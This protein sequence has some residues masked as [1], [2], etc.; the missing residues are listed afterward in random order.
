MR[1]R[2]SAALRAL[3]SAPS[4]H[5][6]SAAVWEIV[7]MTRAPQTTSPDVATGNRIEQ[8]RIAVPGCHRTKEPSASLEVTRRNLFCAA[9]HKRGGRDCDTSERVLIFFVVSCVA[10]PAFSD[11]P[12]FRSHRPT[13]RASCSRCLRRD[14]P[15]P[16]GAGAYDIQGVAGDADNFLPS[17]RMVRSTR[18]GIEI[19]AEMFA[20]P[21]NQ[22]PKIQPATSSIFTL[23]G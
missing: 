1:A 15:G 8:G 7:I 5:Q 18:P 13:S 2:S 20:S 16:A 17:S 3:L 19:P 23:S 11:L 6:C 10:S 14:L 9:A 4:Q 12:A 21:R 22:R